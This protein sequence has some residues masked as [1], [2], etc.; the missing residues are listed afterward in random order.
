MLRG[1]CIAISSY[2]KN[3]NDLRS[4]EQTKIK[5]NRRKEIIKIMSEKW[6]TVYINNEEN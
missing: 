6:N 5:A 2:I 1:K 4:T 3:K